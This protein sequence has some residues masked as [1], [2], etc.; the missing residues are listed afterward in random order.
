MDEIGDTVLYPVR[1]REPILQRFRSAFEIMV[2]PAIEGSE[3]Y[4]QLVE[5]ELGGADAASYHH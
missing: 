5:G 4:A 1:R 3:A 2:I